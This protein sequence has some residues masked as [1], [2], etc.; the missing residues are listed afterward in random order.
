MGKG[1]IA[2]YK[3]KKINETFLTLSE[4]QVKSFIYHSTSISI[5][6]KQIK[7]KQSTER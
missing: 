6:D 2:C 5:V 1:E 3:H 7:N 4:S